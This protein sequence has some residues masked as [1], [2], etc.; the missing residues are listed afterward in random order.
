MFVEVADVTCLRQG[1]ILKGIPF[2]RLN[3][4]EIPLLGTVSIEGSHPAI[5]TLI[6]KTH[7]HRDDPNW[8][9]AQMPVRVSFC[10]VL[11]QCCDL[12]PNKSGQLQLPAFSLA[13]LITI[14]KGIASD[15]QR[16]A[17]LRTNKDPRNA[18][19]PGYI[20][21]FHIPA[22]DQL[23]SKEW[24]VDYNQTICIPGR[25]FPSILSRK[26]LQMDDYNLVKFKIKLSSC[27]TR[28]TNEERAAG[29]ENPWLDTETAVAEPGT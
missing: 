13:R 12:E 25:E 10:V 24:I 9:T 14:P 29:I 2:P 3:L 18:A 4:A 20:N 21:F 19:D 27:L 8:L 7:P 23:E 5:P 6:A 22:H 11:S 26:I 1:D 15:S 28:L 16:L 17:S